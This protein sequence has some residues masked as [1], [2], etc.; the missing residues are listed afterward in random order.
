MCRAE[1]GLSGCLS[2]PV[3]SWSPTLSLPSLSPYP[4]NSLEKHSSSFVTCC[5]VRSHP[6]SISRNNL[7]DV[8]M[9]LNVTGSGPVLS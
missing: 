2:L 6:F 9:L 7:K 4:P 8:E 1:L 3:K 5:S